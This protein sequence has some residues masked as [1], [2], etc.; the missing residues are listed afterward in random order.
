M[1][2][3]QPQENFDARENRLNSVSRLVEDL[4][5]LDVKEEN[6]SD[7]L[8]KLREASDLLRE[9]IEIGKR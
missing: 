1:S 9:A 6:L 7:F 3:E 2:T 4:K 8:L 5:S